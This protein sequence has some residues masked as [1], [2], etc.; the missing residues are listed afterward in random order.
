M[1]ILCNI[2]SGARGLLTS[3]RNHQLSQPTRRNGG[4]QVADAEKKNS[5]FHGH[6]IDCN[7]IVHQQAGGSE[8]KYN[9]WKRNGLTEQ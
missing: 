7:S 4:L 2:F 8:S 6:S 9:Y 5:A 3:L 1:I